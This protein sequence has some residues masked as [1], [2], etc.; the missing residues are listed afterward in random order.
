M[1]ELNP[2]SKLEEKIYERIEQEK[3][4]I[5]RRK[6]FAMRLSLAASAMALFYASA[7]SGPAILHSEFIKMASLAFSDT[8]IVLKNW[9]EFSYSLMESFPGLTVIVIL[10]PLCA[11]LWTVGLYLDLNKKPANGWKLRKV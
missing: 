10:A 8:A 1:D 7:T 4:S 11:L 9:T 2:P 6:I 3:A 5:L